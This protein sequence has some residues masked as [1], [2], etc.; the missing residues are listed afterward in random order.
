MVTGSC[1]TP[2][3][4][5]WPAHPVQEGPGRAVVLRVHVTPV[6]A[7]HQGRAAACRR[8][9]GREA[10]GALV[11]RAVREPPGGRQHG[12]CPGRRRGHCRTRWPARG[13]P[14]TRPGGRRGPACSGWDAG[15]GGRQR[16]HLRGEPRKLGGV[17]EV[18]LPVGGDLGLAR[19]GQVG[20]VLYQACAD[21]PAQGRHVP[22]SLALLGQAPEHVHRD[23]IRPGHPR[24]EQEL[25]ERGGVAG[26]L[27]RLGRLPGDSPDRR[28]GQHMPGP[29]MDHGHSSGVRSER[30]EAAAGTTWARLDGIGVAAQRD[31]RCLR[32]D[33][34][35]RNADGHP[36][37]TG[38]RGRRTGLSYGDDDS[39]GGQR[40]HHHDRN[41]DDQPAV[42]HTLPF[43]QQEATV[44]LALRPR[45]RLLNLTYHTCRRLTQVT[46]YDSKCRKDSDI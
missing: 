9:H 22:A 44:P 23:R 41:D 17:V 5:P 7:Q 29:V 31:L 34:A 33:G 1:G 12:R 4:S 2:E 37:A 3:P 40:G 32:C 28:G 14:G 16:R 30:D 11:R 21:E 35:G 27:R 20:W 36:L 8:G 26:G 25:V 13:A 39:P 38:L 46:R 6:A 19:V 15:Q 45:R 24:G 42:R 10:V 18:D 43:P